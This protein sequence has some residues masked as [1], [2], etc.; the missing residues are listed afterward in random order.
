MP[1]IASIM[2]LTYKFFK[3]LAVPPHAI[4]L[5]SQKNPP[6]TNFFES[7][8]IIEIKKGTIAQLPCELFW[9]LPYV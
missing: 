6:K 1:A 7:F 8:F 3:R 5:A 2:S 9:S 4:P